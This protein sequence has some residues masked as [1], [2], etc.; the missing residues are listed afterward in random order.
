[1][2]EKAWIVYDERGIYDSDEA[3]VLVSCSSLREAWDYLRNDFGSGCI[4]EYDVTPKN[5]L[6]EEHLVGWRST[7]LGCEWR[8]EWDDARPIQAV[9]AKR[10]HSRR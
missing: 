8:A 1:M 5:E 7:G 9:A 2:S 6:V 4:Y 10:A 3:A